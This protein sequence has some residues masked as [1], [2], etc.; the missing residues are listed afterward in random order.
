MGAGERADTLAECG[1]SLSRVGRVSQRLG[2]DRLDH[3]Q[4]VHE[5]VGKF[6]VEEGAL[7]LRQLSILDIRDNRDGRDNVALVPANGCG[8]NL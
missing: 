2:C 4:R 7:L 8:G 3:G 6:P 5:N 1:L